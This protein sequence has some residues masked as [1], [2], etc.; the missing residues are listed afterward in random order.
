MNT[1]A[2]VPKYTVA[3]ELLERAIE[4][5]MRGDSYYAALHLGGAAE[6]VL[7]VYVRAMPPSASNGQ[8]AA[9]DQF[10]DAFLTFSSPAS[11]EER[12]GAERWIHN[13]MFDAKNSV[14]H[15]R[16]RKDEA[17]DFDAEQEAH[18]AID[19]AISTYFQLFSYLNLPC[20]ACIK[21]FDAKGRNKQGT[22]EA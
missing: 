5:Y 16:G 11:P 18:D 3:L 17:V 2:I 21:N 13:R 15:K 22:G 20:L 12:A 1:F 19:L 14:K 4:L 8:R 7:A 6:E 10:K 9:A